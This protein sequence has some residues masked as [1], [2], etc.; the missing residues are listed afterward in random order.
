MFK[1]EIQVY[2][3]LEQFNP[4]GSA[5]DRPALRMISEAWREGAIGPG[6]VIIESS[7]GNMGISLAAICSRFGLRFV[8]VIDPRTTEQ[9]IRILKAYGAEIDYVAEPDEETGEFLPA[10]LNRVRQL[11]SDIPNSYWPNQYENENNYLSHCETTMKEIVTALGKLDYLF[12]AVSTC[13]T[14][15]GCAKYVREHG[16]ATKVV[17]VD[18]V[19]SIIFG[20]QKEARR[21]PGIGAGIV[22]PFTQTLSMDRIVKVS[23]WDMVMGCRQLV[24][25]ESILAGPSSGAVVMALKG[26]ENELPSGS[27]C[28][29][30]IHDRGE[31]YLDTVY[32]NEW[33]ER[34]FGR[35]I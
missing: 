21:F 13:G 14:M 31:R 8:C 19:G 34:Q 16:L 9:N 20:G 1:T 22:P 11:L 32:S 35:N 28:A 10:R 24:H 25:Q 26:M 18:A 17:A 7:S 27:V 30:L 23:D 12:G 33:V 3:K 4:G 15:Y 5:K 6:S 2:A 29:V